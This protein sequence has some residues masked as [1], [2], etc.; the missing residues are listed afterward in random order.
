M[1]TAYEP[2]QVEQRLYQWWEA[3]GFFQPSGASADGT[4]EPF[5]VIMPPPNVT[6]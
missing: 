3:N 4:R 5:T 2:A 6:G 1:A